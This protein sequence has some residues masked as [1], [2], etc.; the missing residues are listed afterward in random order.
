M[1]RRS[2]DLDPEQVRDAIRVCACFNLRRVSRAVTEVYDEA[3]APL[4]LSSGQFMLLLAVRMLGETSL[5]R[6]ADTVWTDRSVLIRT[7]RP[8]EDRGLLAIITGKDRR[9]RRITLT[10]KGQR[11]L[12]DGYVRWQGAQARMGELLGAHQLEELLGTL[13]RSS[14]GVQPKYLTKRSRRVQAK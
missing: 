5:L 4:G 10:P 3:M 12:R 9:T 1:S 7:V 11:A 6:L 2:P 8:L 14:L 13:E